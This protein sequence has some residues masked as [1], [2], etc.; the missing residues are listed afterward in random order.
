MW[1]RPQPAPTRSTSLCARHVLTPGKESPHV[2]EAHDLKKTARKAVAHTPDHGHAP[3]DA[4]ARAR[5]MQLE[6]FN[7]W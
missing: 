2:E 7:V 5:R 6:A 3:V 4:Q 1:G